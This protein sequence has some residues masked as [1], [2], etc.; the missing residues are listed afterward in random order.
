MIIRQYNDGPKSGVCK[1]K[2]IPVINNCFYVL[3]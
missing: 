1:A 2:I 3:G